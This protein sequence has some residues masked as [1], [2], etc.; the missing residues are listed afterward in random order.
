MIELE[1]TPQPRAYNRFRVLVIEDHRDTADS[2]RLVLEL[3]GHDVAVAY[4]AED[5]LHKAK[6]WRPEILLCDIGL[7]GMDGYRLAA[8]IR[9]NPTTANACFIAISGH[10]EQANKGQATQS[11]FDHYLLKPVDPANLENLFFASTP[12]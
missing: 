6:E 7:P 1:A 11:V 8:Q 3:R 2:L 4:D 9:K 5:G 10:A 12:A